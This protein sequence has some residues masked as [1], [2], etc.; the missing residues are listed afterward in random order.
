MVLDQLD[1]SIDGLQTIPFGSTRAEHGGPPRRWITVLVAQRRP[2]RRRC[3]SPH[4]T[5]TAWEAVRVRTADPE[6][7]AVVLPLPPSALLCSY[8][9]PEVLTC[10]SLLEAARGG[11]GRSAPA[12]K[13]SHARYQTLGRIESGRQRRVRT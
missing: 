1:G 8:R 12:V 9:A 4:P 6:R 7:A 5:A 13:T 3:S 10:G 2:A 11:Q